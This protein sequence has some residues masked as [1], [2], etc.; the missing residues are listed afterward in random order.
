MKRIELT[1]A[2]KGANKTPDFI[3]SW[4]IEPESLCD[5]L[6]EFFESN[7]D[8]QSPGESYTGLDEDIKKSTDITVLPRDLENPGY[9]PVRQ[10]I[11][12]LYDCFADYATQWPF[13][14]N[15][16]R[17]EM[18]S[19]NIQRYYEGEHFNELH[20]ERDSLGNL[21]RLMAWMTYLNDVPGGGETHFEYFGLDVKPEKGKT[22]IWPAEWTHAHQGTPVTQGTKYVITGWLHFPPA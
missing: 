12:C 14:K 3:G 7:E 4:L 15:F 18:G 9:E 22:L 8:L 5:D 16:P 20:T 13:L 1:K 19:F 21:H 17:L 6:I 11:V 2:N 10:Y